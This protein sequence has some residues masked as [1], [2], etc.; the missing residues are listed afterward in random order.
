MAQ[1]RE[2]LAGDH[3]TY[4][5]W[6]HAMNMRLKFDRLLTN[7]KRYCKKAIQ[8]EKVMKTWSGLLLNEDGLPDNWVH[9]SGVLNYQRSN[10]LRTIDNQTGANGPPR[11]R[12]MLHF[13]PI[14]ATRAKCD[15]ET[16]QKSMST[17]EIEVAALDVE[18]AW[19]QRVGVSGVGWRH[20]I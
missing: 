6:I 12:I 18:G 15:E 11:S 20:L 14:A 2:K 3:E 16:L 9:Q 4:N 10:Y 17:M 5:R 19:S 1:K 13:S 7:S 8:A